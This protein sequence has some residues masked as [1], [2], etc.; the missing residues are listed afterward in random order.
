MVV[1][2]FRSEASGNCLYSSVSLVLVGDNSLVPILRKLTSIELF[3]NANFYSQHPLFLSIVEKHSEFSNSLKNLLLLSVSQECLDSGLT[4][5]ALVKKEAYLNCHDKKW[6]SFVCIFGLSSVIGRCIRT[7]YP[8][9]A[10]IRPKLMFNS[11]IHPS[12]PSKISSDALHILFCHEE[13][14]NP[15]D[16]EV[17]SV[18]IITHSKLK[19]LICCCYRPPNAEKIWLDKFN[20]IL[21]DLLSRHD[22]IIICGDF[23]FPKVNWQSPAKTFGAD[24]I[25]FTEQLN[26][27]YLIQLNTLAT[28]GVNILDLVISS[29]PN[30]INNIILL[31]P[32]NSSLFTDHSVIIFDLKTSIRAGPRLNRSVLDF[33]RGDFEG[34]HSALQVTDLSTIIQQDSDI[35]EDWLLWKDTFLTTVNDFVPSQKIK[36]RNSLSWL[37]GK[38]LNRRQRVTVLGATSSEKPVMS[39][40]P[41]GSILGPILFLLYVNDL[42]DVVNNAK[43]ASFADDTKLFKCVDSHTDGASIQSDLDNLEWSTSSGLVFNQ[44]KC[45]CQRITRK[46]TTTEFP[47]TLKN[48]TLAVTTEEKDLGIWV[49]RI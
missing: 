34:L 44:N 23:N 8:D 29:V 31:N 42:P 26:N 20:S 4:I 24:E 11:L 22:N 27:F 10:E 25:S 32:E 1:H 40:V 45:K 43:V 7:Y 35:N 49:T 17:T 21:A 13:L 14:V 33:R 30:Q 36:G 5:D 48:K 41:Q 3:M 37:N 9:S 39:G 2:I 28:R 16:L 18:E 15:S 12:N 46:K 6:A 47:Y 19:L 38:L